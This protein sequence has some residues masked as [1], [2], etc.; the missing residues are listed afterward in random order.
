MIIGKAIK[1]NVWNDDQVHSL[2]ERQNCDYIHPYTCICGAGEM[3]VKSYGLTCKK[4]GY[5]QT[6]VLPGDLNWEWKK[7]VPNWDELNELQL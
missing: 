5:I 2:T 6:K 1:M 4:C 7:L 3:Q